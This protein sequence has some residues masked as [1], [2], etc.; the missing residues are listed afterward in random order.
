[1]VHK[2]KKI[3]VCGAGGFIGFHLVEELKKQG[4]YVIAADIKLPRFGDSVA[5][6]FNL[7]DLRDPSLVAQLIT[8]NIDEIYQLA[9]DMGG[10]GYIGTG[11][12]DADIM[13]NSALINLNVLHEAT[14]K[15]ISKILY[16]SSACVY[17]EFNQEDPNNPNCEEYTAYPAQPDTEYGWEKLFSERLYFAHAKNYNIDAKVVRLHNV[18]GPSGSWND[19]KE[20]APAALCRKIAECEE[21]GTVEIWGPGTQTRTFLYIDECIKGLLKVMA[22]DITIPVNLGSERMISINDLA[23]LI[24]DIAD[25]NINIKNV[26]GPIGVMGRSSHNDLIEELLKWRPAENLEYGLTHTYEWIEGQ[27]N[28]LQ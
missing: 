11:E 3:L 19:G 23:Y 20:K 9:A 25:K 2:M 15:R 8:P 22:S 26:S 10:T 18:F 13:H 21:G 5:D 12:H 16:T 14:K 27:V 28:A 1:M 17:P 24:A 7:Y 4:H 6:E